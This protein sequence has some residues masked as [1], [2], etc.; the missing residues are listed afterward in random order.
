M[1]SFLPL[2][3]HKVGTLHG[4]IPDEQLVGEHVSFCFFGKYGT[5]YEL[6]EAKR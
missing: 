4:V 2:D 3:R 6:K 1:S 5:Q